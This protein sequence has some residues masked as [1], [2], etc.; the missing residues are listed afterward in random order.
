MH[1][2]KTMQTADCQKF[3]MGLIDYLENTFEVDLKSIL[4]A[5]NS[6][7][8]TIRSN[9]T[10]TLTEAVRKYHTARG[11]SD[12]LSTETASNNPGAF[13]VTSNWFM[14]EDNALDYADLEGDEIIKQM[15]YISSNMSKMLESKDYGLASFYMFASGF[16]ATTTGGAIAFIG[17]VLAGM[18]E[19]EAIAAGL[20]TLKGGAIGTIVILVISMIIF[21]VFLRPA[22]A[23]GFVVNN[24]DKNLIVDDFKSSSGDLFMNTGKMESFMQDK[25]DPSRVKSPWIQIHGKMPWLIDGKLRTGVFAGFYFAEKRDWA[26]YGTDGAMIFSST[27]G[28]LK[29]AHEFAVPYSASNGTN[30]KLLENDYSGNAKKVFSDLRQ[31]Q[32]KRVVV[33]TDD[34][35][36]TSSIND[37]SGQECGIIATIHQK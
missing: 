29:F 34:Y 23:L 16:L 13:E 9:A 5:E 22:K 1:H 15:Q 8:K 21:F 37:T 6:N 26:L 12:W 31:N 20:S 14:T 4:F 27:D 3:G 17:S 11:N 24:T 33:S 36:L 32:K 19:A 28:N 7:I 35:E 2:L 18:T 25:E 10:K 30:I